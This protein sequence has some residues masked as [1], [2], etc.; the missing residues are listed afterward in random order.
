MAEM[1]PLNEAIMDLLNLKKTRETASHLNK[2]WHSTLTL[3]HHT[4]FLAFCVHFIYN[5]IYFF[6]FV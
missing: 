2:Y 6:L 3:H 1:N 4:V 5:L